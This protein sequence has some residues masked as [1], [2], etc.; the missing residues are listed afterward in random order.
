MT[1]NIAVDVVDV[2]K[3]FRLYTEKYQSLKERVLHAGRNPYQ[4]F[5]ALRDINFEIPEGQTVGILGR[6]GSGKS[7]LLKCVSGILQPTKGKVVVRGSLAAL[8]ELGAGF[9]PELSGRE[10]IYLNASLLGLSTKDVD[11]RFDEIVAF[12]E[13]EQFI[14]NQVKY[15]SSGM[16][17]RLGFA[18]A[19]NV[20]PDILVVDEVLAV[21]DEAFSRKCMARIKEFQ[22]DGRT[23]LFVTHSSDLVRQIC[24]FA[25]VLSSGDMIG[26]GPAADAVRIYHEHLNTMGP[27]IGAAPLEL[28]EAPAPAPL[29]RAIEISSVDVEHP[30]LGSR[31]YLLPWEPLTVHV[32][33]EATEPVPGV[34]FA[35][36]IFDQEGKLIFGSDTEIL[37]RPFDAPIGAGR[38]DLSFERVPLLD[39]AYSMKVEVK[40]RLGI[41]YDSREQ[42]AFE[43]MNPDRSRGSVALELHADI[44]A[45]S[46][47]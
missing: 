19:V 7:T 44:R 1:V 23:I 25:V 38:A 20:D 18:V 37:D 16:Y 4:D 43:V 42:Q 34:V 39:G 2:T 17:V 21:G 10:N 6:N 22:D 12:A 31:P 8:L 33:F 45:A 3:R 15:Y 32:A 5:F 26:S 46:L 28:E 27:A 11:K 14:D 24:D 35:L 47:S 41:L 13:L 40:D 29:H 9:Q 30:G 36:E